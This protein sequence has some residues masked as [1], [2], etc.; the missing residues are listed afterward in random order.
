M[1]SFFGIQ[2]WFRRDIS[3]LSGGQKQL[4][5]LASV[6]VM[7]PEVLILDEPTSQLDPLAAADFLRAVKRV[8]LELGT[9]II[10]SEHRLEEVFPLADKIILM[11]KAKVAMYDET[12][13]VARYLA[14]RE[15]QHDMDF[16]LL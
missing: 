12:K 1:A 5:N 3:E 8:N 11:D 9:L 10:I 7:Q 14:N 2:N 16:H 15:N 6:M 4:L 13:K